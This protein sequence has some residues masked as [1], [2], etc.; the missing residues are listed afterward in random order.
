[1][2]K[3]NTIVY[4]LVSLVVIVLVVST[5]AL[6]VVQDSQYSVTD[7]AMNAN[8]RYTISSPSE[9]YT[10][11]VIDGALS[12]NGVD[13]DE[14]LTGESGTAYIIWDSGSIEYYKSAGSWTTLGTIYVYSENDGFFANQY[15]KKVVCSNGTITATT[16]ANVDYT[17][18]Y[19]FLMCPD[20]NGEYGSYNRADLTTE[21][22]YADSSSTIYIYDGYYT[23]TM[24]IAKG[25]YDDINV[26]IACANSEVTTDDVSVSFVTT[27][28]DLNLS[29]KLDSISVTG[30]TVRNLEIFI[31]I[32][33]TTITEN[34]SV[35]YTL[36][37]IIPLLLMIIPVM[38]V[39]RLVVN[40]RD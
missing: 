27:P 7:K 5:V 31:P 3:I 18:S 37:A 1:M 17:Y 12:F 14:I 38:I 15:I 22:I 35:I 24:L 16:S 11:E 26:I 20:V 9:T 28:T 36:L 40:G 10:I 39:A 13:P 8:E 32:E 25:T 23:H 29:N 21:S 4:G 33:Y 30:Q 34:N 6:P 19:T 2:E